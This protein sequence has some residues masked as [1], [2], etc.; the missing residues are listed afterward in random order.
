MT[1]ICRVNK[2]YL[3]DVEVFVFLLLLR[4]ALIIEV[5]IAS[6]VDLDVIGDLL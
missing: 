5:I 3:V 1:Q 6:F 2:S 4:A